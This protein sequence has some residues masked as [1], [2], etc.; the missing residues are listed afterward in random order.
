MGYFSKLWCEIF[1]NCNWLV[2]RW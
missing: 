2:T 1:I